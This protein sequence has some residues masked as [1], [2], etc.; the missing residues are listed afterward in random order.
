MTK[1][2]F[3]DSFVWG[4]VLWLFGYLLGILFFSFVPQSILGWVITP[5]GVLFTLWVLFKKVH[6]DSPRDYVLM[7]IVW[8]LIAVVCDYFLL[9]QVF[10][11]ADGYY[12]LD[13]YVY[14]IFTF[15][16]PLAVRFLKKSNMLK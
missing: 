14:Y 1:Q 6:P 13:V 3:K 7:A 8:V 2:L 15:V 9:V 11:P 4:F 10:K 16:L 5:F 12:K